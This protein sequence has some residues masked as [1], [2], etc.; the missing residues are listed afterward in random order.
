MIDNFYDETFRRSGMINE[1]AYDGGN[2]LMPTD[3]K[4]M[5]YMGTHCAPMKTKII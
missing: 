1:C 4:P 5:D 3:G 2:L